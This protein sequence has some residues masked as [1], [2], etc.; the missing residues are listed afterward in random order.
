MEY[1]TKAESEIR[2][3]YQTTIPHEIR[4]RAHLEI[5]DQLLWMYDETRNEIIVMAKPKNFTDAI[6]GLG[7]EVWEEGTSDQYV[8]K[9]RDTW[10]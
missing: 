1:T 3:R 5:G 10:K 9:E 4:E 2:Q 6:W 8:L 7:K